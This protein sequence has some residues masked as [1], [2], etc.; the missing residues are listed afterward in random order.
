MPALPALLALHLGVARR[1]RPGAHRVD[2]LVVGPASARVAPA[3][4][5][6]P[7]D[8]EATRLGVAPRAAGV[9]PRRVAA[10]AGDV[11]PLAEVALDTT[12]FRAG[13]RYRAGAT[14]GTLGAFIHIPVEGDAV[15]PVVRAQPAVALAVLSR[16]RAA[17]R[18]T[19]RP[20]AV[21][22]VESDP[23]LAAPCLGPE[24]V[25]RGLVGVRRHAGHRAAQA[26]AVIHAGMKCHWTAAD[27]VSGPNRARPAARP[28]KEV[29]RH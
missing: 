29:R 17:G 2:A 9:E 20:V 16:R 24:R 13:A 27:L 11:V 22:V 14:L 10:H 8:G 25:E 7:L 28:P 4:A 3:F 6:N 23:D 18:P 1:R 12:Q 5:G 15:V 26:R 21:G 19:P